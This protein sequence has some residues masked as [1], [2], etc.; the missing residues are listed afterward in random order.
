MR[1]V[2]HGAVLDKEGGNGDETQKH[3][4]RNPAGGTNWEKTL[5]T[6][7]GEGAPFLDPH[8]CGEPRRINAI[9]RFL[10]GTDKEG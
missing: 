1:D 10:L 8:S 3:N 9:D 7:L 5:R 2:E 6:K 4:T